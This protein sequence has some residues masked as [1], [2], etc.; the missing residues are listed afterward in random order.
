M[1]HLWLSRNVCIVIINLC[2]LLTIDH[3]AGK[4]C[5]VELDS[6]CLNGKFSGTEQLGNSSRKRST[7]GGMHRPNGGAHGSGKSIGIHYLPSRGA[8]TTYPFTRFLRSFVKLKA[9]YGINFYIHHMTKSMW[10]P[11][12]YPPDLGPKK[13]TLNLKNLNL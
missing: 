4:V 6:I 3:H 5:G 11:V 7:P 8:R 12:Y 1:A 2:F 9:V 10:T 13:S